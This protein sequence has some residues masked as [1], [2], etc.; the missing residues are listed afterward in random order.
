MM[1]LQVTVHQSPVERFPDMRTRKKAQTRLA[2]Q[3]AAL[4]L[5]AEQGYEAT[6]V[7]QIALRAD[8]SA[9]TFFRYFGTK[10]DII[11]NDHDAR[12]P[13]LCAAIR[14]Q[15]GEIGDFEAV[16]L[17]L[18]AVWVPGVDAVRTIRTTRAVA[19]SA[20]L[21]GLAYDV[22]VGW[23]AA[24]AATLVDRRADPAALEECLLIARTALGVF[25]TAA[26]H[27]G[28]TG[29]E[30]DFGALIDRGFEMIAR[31]CR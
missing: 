7:E 31:I 25:G 14:A 19:Q 4:D 17:A 2:I 5:F 3:D 6:T 24:V 8:V 21:R 16:R 15:P 23:M 20:F 28:A 1:S 10:A 11:L 30:E 22:G 13:T 12:L 27:W 29:A 26:G 9:S 18:H